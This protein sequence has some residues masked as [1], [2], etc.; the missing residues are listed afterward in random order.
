MSGVAFD[1]EFVSYMVEDHRKD[2]AD[3]KKEASND[4]GPADRLAQKQLP[5]LEKHLKIAQS[6]SSERLSRR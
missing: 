4:K 1:R 5:T 3:F 2:I 6:L